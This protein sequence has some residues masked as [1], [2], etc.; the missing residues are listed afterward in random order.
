MKKI[1]ISVP[2]VSVLNSIFILLEYK[3]ACYQPDDDRGLTHEN[4]LGICEDGEKA[5]TQHTGVV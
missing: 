1:A 3:T 2:L 4:L 5:Y